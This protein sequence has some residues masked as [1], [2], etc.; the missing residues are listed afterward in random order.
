MANRLP[1]DSYFL[2]ESKIMELDFTHLPGRA[3]R[4]RAREAAAMHVFFLLIALFIY[5]AVLGLS[6][7]IWEWDLVPQAGVKPGPPVLGLCRL[8]H[9]TTK[10]VPVNVF[11]M[12]KSNSQ[13]PNCTG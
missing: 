3:R 13:G 6:C 4:A 11:L 2:C 5:L 8:S 9:W 10:K 1:C 7:S 12:M